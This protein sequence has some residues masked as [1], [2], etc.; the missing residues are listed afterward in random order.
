MKTRKLAV[1]SALVAIALFAGWQ[2][3]LESKGAP[4]GLIVYAA[5]YGEPE[6]TFYRDIAGLPSE[7]WFSLTIRYYNNDVETLYFEITGEGPLSFQT[8]R[9]GSLTKGSVSDY[10]LLS[11]FASRAKPSAAD[12]NNGEKEETITLVLRAYRDSG[13][14]NL[15]WTFKRDVKIH[16]I[17]SEDPAFSTVLLDT[18]NDG[19]V[20]GWTYSIS[21]RW[22]SG[23]I[24]VS[25]ESFI[26]APYSLYGYASVYSQYGDF[27]ADY[28]AKKSINTPNAEKI[29]ATINVR[30]VGYVSG[31]EKSR[32]YY[33]Y[34]SFAGTTLT[35]VG[36][37]PPEAQ[38]LRLTV[39]LKPNTNGE[40]TI[41][42]RAFINAYG[43]TIY[44]RMW[45]DD[46]IIVAK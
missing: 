7:T 26:S 36:P 18:F 40:L 42:V 43:S 27:T 17:N 2:M 4:I 5:P 3:F 10:T 35:T 33:I 14:S 23:S 24:S 12:L 20:S 37:Y 39:P 19:S 15:K 25:N 44:L 29:F 31:A 34:V 46:I 22:K 45:F 28:Y 21:T 9:L 13:Y 32:L 30:A 6:F 8:I 16:W 41:Q 1:V 38:W 11:N